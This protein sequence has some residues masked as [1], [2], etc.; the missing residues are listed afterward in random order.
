MQAGEVRLR[1]RQ[2]SSEQ[3]FKVKFQ[4]Q[5]PTAG[6]QSLLLFTE[7]LLCPRQS[8]RPQDATVNQR[9]SLPSQ[10]SHSGGGGEGGGGNKHYYKKTYDPT[11]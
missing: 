2:T 5:R 9:K 1:H 11:S 7:R 4:A 6:V 8:S 3:R 10:G